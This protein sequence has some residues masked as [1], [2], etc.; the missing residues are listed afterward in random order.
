MKSLPLFLL[1]C[2]RRERFAPTAAIA[3]R[4]AEELTGPHQVVVLPGISSGANV[5]DTDRN[6]TREAMLE[7]LRQYLPAGG[8]T[9]KER[10]PRFTHRGRL[11][12][13]TFTTFLS[14]PPFFFLIFYAEQASCG[15]ERGSYYS[16]CLS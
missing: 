3:G 1:V 13:P 4:M 14:T 6:Q 16:F 8:A 7:R 10:R 12:P 2:S 9:H 5:L 15:R 11:R